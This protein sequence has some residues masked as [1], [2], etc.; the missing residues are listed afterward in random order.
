MPEQVIDAKP[1]TTFDLD[2]LRVQV[3]EARHTD[4]DAVGFRFKT[5][6]LGDIAYTSDTE[7]FPGIG[8]PYQDVRLLLL[9]VM[10]PA[11]S[12]WKGHMTTEDAIQ[13]LNEA[14]PEMAVLTHFGM[15]MIFKGPALEAKHIQEKTG[16]QTIAGSD[17]M[18]ITIG[19][20]IQMQTSKSKQ[21]GLN[22]FGET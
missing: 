20:K 22:E 12:P 16:I 19:E 15:Q 10:R 3:A 14:K 2:S 21:R 11:G 13:I 18:H 17:G 8:K 5:P 4:P 1:D 7:Y 6:S 9:C